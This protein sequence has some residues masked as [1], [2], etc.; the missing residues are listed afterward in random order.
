MG[1][2]SDFERGEIVG[3]P[4]T[5]SGRRVESDAT[6]PEIMSANTNQGKKT[7]VKRSSWRKSTLTETDTEKHC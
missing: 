6:I 7:S 5:L 1:D 3:A 2:L 4:S